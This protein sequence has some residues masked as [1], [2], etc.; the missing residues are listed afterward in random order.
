MLLSQKKG[1]MPFQA[2]VSLL[3]EVAPPLMVHEAQD[4]T[5]GSELETEGMNSI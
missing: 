4:K 1:N 5:R 2:H 3:M